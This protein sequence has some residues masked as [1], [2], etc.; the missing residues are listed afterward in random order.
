MV[1][2]NCLQQE[3][4]NS[5]GVRKV[6]MQGSGC[7][8]EGVLNLPSGAQEGQGGPET[9]AFREVLGNLIFWSWEKMGESFSSKGHLSLTAL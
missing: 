8:G 3:V 4:D 1:G 2:W 6:W 5:H 9:L 7:S